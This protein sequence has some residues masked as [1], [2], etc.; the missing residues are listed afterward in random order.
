MMGVHVA[1]SSLG[2]SSWYCWGDFYR[3]GAGGI[4]LA[5]GEISRANPE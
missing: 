1:V 5:D 3:H 2:F 4:P